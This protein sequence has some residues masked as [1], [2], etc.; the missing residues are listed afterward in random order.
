LRQTTR[1]LVTVV[2]HHRQ[3]APNIPRRLDV[4][5]PATRKAAAKARGTLSKLELPLPLAMM[6][7]WPS[8]SW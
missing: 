3:A 7:N 4:R 8:R 1:K 6:P 2:G 5:I